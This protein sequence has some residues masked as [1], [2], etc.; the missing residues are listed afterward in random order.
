LVSA[1]D[2]E[3]PFAAFSSESLSVQCPAG[4][5]ILGGGGSSGEPDA[6]VL[7]GSAPQGEGWVATFLFIGAEGTVASIST[8]ATCATV[9]VP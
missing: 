4:T 9:A 8:F 3:R 2:S 6:I 7:S 5:R 1:T